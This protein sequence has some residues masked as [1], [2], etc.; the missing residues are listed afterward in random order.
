MSGNPGKLYNCWPNFQAGPCELINSV[1]FLCFAKSSLFL[2]EGMFQSKENSYS[3][4]QILSASCY[5]T[6]FPEP[7]SG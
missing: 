2:W 3:I 7:D 5:S 1:N 4:L 6:L